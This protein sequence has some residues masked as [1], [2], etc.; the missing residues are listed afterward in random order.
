MDELANKIIISRN[1]PE[2]TY[3]EYFP[4]YIIIMI[5]LILNIILYKLKEK[6]ISVIKNL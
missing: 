2:N 6:C 4:I 3:N 1:L 5:M